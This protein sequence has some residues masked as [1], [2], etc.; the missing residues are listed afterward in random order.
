M[1]P[2][3]INKAI[4]FYKTHRRVVDNLIK[5]KTVNNYPPTEVEDKNDPRLWKASHWKWLKENYQI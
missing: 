5:Q 2:E 3:Q 1:K 4:D